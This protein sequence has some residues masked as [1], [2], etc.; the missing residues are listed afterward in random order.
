[1]QFG[2]ASLPDTFLQEYESNYRGLLADAHEMQVRIRQCDDRRTAERD[3][4]RCVHG[5]AR[6]RHSL[7]M[8]RDW[9]R[10]NLITHDQAARLEALVGNVDEV[11]RRAMAA[12][13]IAMED[14]PDIPVPGTLTVRDDVPEL[15]LMLAI[16]SDELEEDLHDLQERAAG[17]AD[18]PTDLELDERDWWCSDERAQYLKDLGLVREWRKVHPGPDLESAEQALVLYLDDIARL[19]AMITSCRDASVDRRIAEQRARIAAGDEMH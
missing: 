18:S 9:Q 4:Q 15:L 1:M 2:V 19:Q 13:R 11:E 5:L 14:L 12:A 8:V 7:D 10:H 6:N 17:D 3:L 16:S